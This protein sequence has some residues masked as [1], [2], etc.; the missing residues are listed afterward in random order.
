MKDYILEMIPITSKIVRAFGRWTDA[1][2][3]P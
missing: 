1:N 3:R 2:A